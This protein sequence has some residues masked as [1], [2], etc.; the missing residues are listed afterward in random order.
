[1]SYGND[2]LLSAIS[3]FSAEKVSYPMPDLWP[4]VYLPEV[5]NT[6]Y[7]MSPTILCSALF[8]I[9]KGTLLESENGKKKY[10]RKF[11][12]RRFT[13]TNGALIDYRGFELCQDDLSVL[14]SLLKK[15]AGF[16]CSLPI[17]LTPSNFCT[18]IGWSDNATNIV[19]LKESLMRLR[20]AFLIITAAARHGTE[21]SKLAKAIGNGWTMN[22]LADFSFN[23]NRWQVT[24]DKRIGQLFNTAATYLIVSRRQSLTEGLQTWLYGYI[25]SNT[26]AYAI[27]V[28]KLH[29]ACGSTATLKEF[30]RQVREAIPKLVA[31]RALLDCSSVKNGKVCLFKRHSGKPITVR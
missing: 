20:F 18:Q 3:A 7:A 27:T 15:H 17:E 1:M 16:A 13:T 8:G 10:T 25:E 29:T 26:C 24:L 11:I 14:L 9:G 21:V 4:E 5:R 19:R 30:S 28:E 2:E 31:A 22:F 23:E 6:S 12:E